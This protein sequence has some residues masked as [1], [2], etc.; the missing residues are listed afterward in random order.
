MKNLLTKTLLLFITISLCAINHE[1]QEKHV[2]EEWRFTHVV[3]L[4][5]VVNFGEVQ[6]SYPEK[7]QFDREKE[8]SDIEYE[9]RENACTLDDD[10]PRL[11]ELKNRMRELRNQ[12]QDQVKTEK[13]RE[14]ALYLS[15][16]SSEEVLNPGLVCKIDGGVYNISVQKEYVRPIS[17]DWPPTGLR[18]CACKRDYYYRCRCAPTNVTCVSRHEQAIVELRDDNLIEIK[19]NV[20]LPQSIDLPEQ[21]NRKILSCTTYG[22]K[23]GDK[24]AV[25]CNTGEIFIFSK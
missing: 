3:R 10:N 24:I 8:L 1:K 13:K 14:Q 11:K 16:L 4:D 9:L 23:K 15:G 18:T 7:L 21:E 6:C 20:G 12:G 17:S 2:A 25:L 5:K 22:H 19:D